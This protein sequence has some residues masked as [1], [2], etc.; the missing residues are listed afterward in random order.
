MTD[1]HIS[2]ALTRKPL[3]D[4][5]LRNHNSWSKSCLKQKDFKVTNK[6]K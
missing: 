1:T 3:Q 6:A 2:Y 5:H 4:A